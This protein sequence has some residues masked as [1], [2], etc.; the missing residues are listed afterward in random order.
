MSTSLTHF[1]L[2]FLS[3]Y[4]S[5]LAQISLFP[6]FH[7][8]TTT[9]YQN[10]N[11]VIA[12]DPSTSV[13]GHLTELENCTKCMHPVCCPCEKS[14]Y[15]CDGF[16]N[17][18]EMSSRRGA[19]EEVQDLGEESSAH[20]TES[21]PWPSSP[22]I[23]ILDEILSTYFTAPTPSSAKNHSCSHW[24]PSKEKIYALGTPKP[25]IKSTSRK[26]SSDSRSKPTSAQSTLGKSTTSKVKILLQ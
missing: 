23:E 10:Q 18:P 20:H 15:A 24:H 13:A 12:A 21:D 2:F 26:K 3:R 9:Q 6:S 19:K 14:G 16:G 7:K 8:L 4:S 17:P 22:E 25:P 5:Y 1:P 11:E